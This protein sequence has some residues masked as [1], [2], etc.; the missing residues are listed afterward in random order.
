M[1]NADLLKAFVTY[2]HLKDMDKEKNNVLLNEG[3]IDWEKV[4]DKLPKDLPI[5]LEYPCNTKEILQLEINKIYKRW[6]KIQ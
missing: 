3:V 5:A 4:I 1:K 6:G 2:I